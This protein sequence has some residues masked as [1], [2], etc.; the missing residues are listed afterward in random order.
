MS[1]YPEHFPGAWQNIPLEVRR[2]LTARLLEQQLALHDGAAGLI[3][4]LYSGRER[5]DLTLLESWRMSAER[6]W[7]FVVADTEAW[8]ASRQPARAAEDDARSPVITLAAAASEAA[9]R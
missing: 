6:A 9:I 2:Y 5:P 7:P 8:L 1:A 3:K 4:S